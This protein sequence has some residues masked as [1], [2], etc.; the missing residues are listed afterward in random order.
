MEYETL[1]YPNAIPGYLENSVSR[2]FY[3]AG[4]GYSLE[5]ITLKPTPEKGKS[6]LERVFSDKSKTLKST[7]K[8]LLNEITLREALDSHLL[9]KMDDEICRLHT[10]LMQLDNITSNY[11]PDFEKGLI[12]RKAQL[13][14]NALELEREKRSEYLE[15][16]RDL[17]FLKKY[18][19]AS[20]KDYWDLVK[21]SEVLSYNSSELIQNENSK[22][23]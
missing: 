22:G 16:W 2:P 23:S 8:A 3:H 13:E 14:N 12:K 15:C 19:H 5:D 10:D 11:S 18:L 4:L 17:M 7:V 20:L 9:R 1:K 21:K 6:V